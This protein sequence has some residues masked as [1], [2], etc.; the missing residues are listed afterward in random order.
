MKPLR[1][2]LRSRLRLLSTLAAGAAVGL[3]L[4]STLPAVRRALVGWNVGVWLYLGL[5][6]A[7]MVRADHRQ[8]RRVA[9]LHAEGAVAVTAGAVCAVVASL[10]SIVIEL[11]SA[12]AE[13]SLVLGH[14]GF[15]V[16]TLV[17]CWLLLPMLFAQTYASLYYRDATATHER[18]RGL[19]FPGDEQHPDYTDFLYFAITVAATAQTS[20]VGITTREMRHWVTVQTLLAFAFNTALLALAINIAAG[21]V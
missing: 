8:L 9:V 5:M 10:S 18:G 11:S 21:L 16:L 13:H 3:L 15:A 20:D 14:L 6:L 1:L 2:H 19:D 17:G 7:L 4:P 12:K